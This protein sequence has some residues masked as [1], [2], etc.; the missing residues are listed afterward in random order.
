MK[1]LRVGFVMSTEVGLRT[2]YLNWRHG[3]SRHPTIRPEW[4]VIN[5]W[6]DGG[7][8]ER[9]PLI[10]RAI[11][12]RL[13]A[14]LELHVGLSNGPF[15][16]LFVAAPDV[17][18]GQARRLSR[19]PYF[20]T[21][22]STWES[23]RALSHLYGKQPSAFG[24]YE[25]QKHHAR[26]ALVRNASALFPWSQWAADSLVRDYGAE[27][28]RIHVIA[29]GVDLSQWKPP[30]KR[31]GSEQG[32]TNILFVGGDFYRKGG[33]LLLDWA[34]HT[35]ARNW[36]LHLVT[37]DVVTPVCER[38][39]VYNGLSSNDPA[40]VRLYET[41]DAFVLPTRGDCY[42][43]A[44]I[45]AMATGLPVVLSR[46]GGTEDIVANG[47]TGYLIEPGDRSALAKCLEFLLSHP[48]QRLQMGQAARRNAEARYDVHKNI[49]RTICVMRSALGA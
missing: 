24:W 33:D 10:P 9:S 39:R 17:F 35:G 27:P 20:V 28:S 38:V 6:K 43:L 8:L 19:Q 18:Y 26:E 48:E 15:D 11:K 37:R 41:A 25:R 1:N 30:A 3:L 23:F 40:L 4:I 29:P 45:E 5:W 12:T 2:Q 14:Y 13:R 7:R 21:L 44:A 36:T 47:E 32:S 22:D 31:R 42:S 49:E 34:A 46:T 16:A